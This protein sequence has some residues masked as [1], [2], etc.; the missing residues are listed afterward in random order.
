[1]LSRSNLHE[2]RILFA[3]PPA[4]VAET[5]IDSANLEVKF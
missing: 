4:F 1:M 3:V 2:H 5:E